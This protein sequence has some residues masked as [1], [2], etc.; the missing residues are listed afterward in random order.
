MEGH[1]TGYGIQVNRTR[2]SPWHTIGGM[3]PKVAKQPSVHEILWENV[4]ALMI[5]HN[6]DKI[7]N[8]NWLAR[9]TGI[10]PGSASRIKSKQ[11]AVGLDVLAKIARR[12]DLQPWHLLMPGLEPGNAPVAFLSD[13]EKKLYDRLKRG[14]EVMTGV[15]E[16][17]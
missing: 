6:P 15:E 13:D 3:P 8:L 10:G 4:R 14:H 2:Y 17:A 16:E 12:F 5:H 1:H 7:E 9:E 11:T